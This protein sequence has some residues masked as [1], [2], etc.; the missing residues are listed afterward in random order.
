MNYPEQYASRTLGITKNVPLLTRLKEQKTDMESRLA[1]INNAIVALEGNP[2]VQSV[3][4]A[5]NKLGHY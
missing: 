1:D 4:E 5:L 2:E 3:I